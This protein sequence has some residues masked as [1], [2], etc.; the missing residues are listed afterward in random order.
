MNIKLGITPKILI[1]EIMLLSCTILL[2]G[3]FFIHKVRHEAELDIESIEQSIIQTKKQ[4]LKNITNI[5]YSYIDSVYLD[6]SNA[7]NTRSEAELQADVT[8]KIQTFRYGTENSDYFWIH[9]YNPNDPDT[10]K[11]IMHPTV[12][13]LNGADISKYRYSNGQQKGE[14]VYATGIEGKVPFFAQMN[15]VVRKNNEGYVRYDWPKPIKNKLTE[16]QPK[17][18]YVRLFDKWNWVIGT[19]VY[20]SDIETAKKEKIEDLEKNTNEIVWGIVWIF[21][22]ILVVATVVLYFMTNLITRKIKEIVSTFAHIAEKGDLTSRVEIYQQDEIG[23]LSE[24]LNRFLAQLQEIIKGIITYADQFKN[25]AEEMAHSSKQVS[26]NSSN[27]RSD[28]LSIIS[29]SAEAAAGTQAMVQSAEEMYSNIVSVQASIEQLSS[30][31]NT[32]AASNEQ[33]SANMAGINQN[34]D[35]VHKDIKS[36]VSLVET[37]SKTMIDVTQNI[38]EAMVIS[39]KVQKNAQETLGTMNQLGETAKKT[40]QIVK[41]IASIASQTNMLALNATIEAASAGEAGKGFAVVAAEVKNLAQQ[42]AEANSEIA[43]QLEQMQKQTLDALKHSQSVSDVISKAAELNHS[44]KK[45][46]EEQSKATTALSKAIQSIS[47]SSQEMVLN[48]KEATTGLK[49]IARSMS[50]AS[51]AAKESARNVIAG[52]QKVK[53]ISKSL[54]QV[55]DEVNK[56]DSSIKEIGKAIDVMDTEAS[57]SLSSADALAKMAIELN[58]MVSIF[59]VGG[60]KKTTLPQVIGRG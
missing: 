17:L 31:I 18:S 24:W 29:S 21:T 36:V 57:H 33:A 5:V 43:L 30:S 23:E 46:V 2:L 40:G 52:S 41:L 54:P 28:V 50:E 42:T 3:S 6:S 37:M 14:I 19:G 16:H 1:L 59:N 34:T 51:Q 10:M 55:A 48:I 13:A 39:D 56:V 26:S 12:P 15:R 32:V 47:T 35:Q 60:E 58:Q 49:E 22:G 25:E 9:A 7:K 38:Q 27:V 8:K 45:A 11:M 53:V 4:E 44:N 20:L